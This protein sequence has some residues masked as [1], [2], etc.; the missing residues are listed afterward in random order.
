MPIRGKKGERR[1]TMRRKRRRRKKKK[2]E[3]S[4]EE[5]PRPCGV[6]FLPGNFQAFEEMKKMSNLI[7]R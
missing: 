6:I 2:K 5:E 1:K 4:E 7:E 3:E